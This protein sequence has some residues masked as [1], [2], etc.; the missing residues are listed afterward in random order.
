[1]TAVAL[2]APAAVAA[3]IR[4]A[5][6]DRHLLLLLDFDGT[7]CGFHPDPAAVVVPDRTQRALDQLAARSDVTVGVISGRRLH[8]VRSRLGA[9]ADIYV[10]GFHGLEIAGRDEAYFHPEAAAAAT[11]VRAI[12][13]TMRPALRGLPGVFIEDK[14]L[15]IALH[16]RDAT[17][18]VGVV[19]QRA[20]LDAAREDLDAGRLRVLPG[21]CVVELLPAASWHKGRALEWIRE[22]AEARHGPVFTVYVGD[23]VT[24]EDAFRAIGDAGLAVAASDRVRHARVRIDGPDGVERLL[25]CLD[26]PADHR[27]A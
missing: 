22:R 6:G 13:E 12:I 11:T 4:A 14:D 17:P 5:R 27:R 10:A 26:A 1:M 8:D 19:A 15:S 3:S 18:A 21:D 9:R 24:D 23:D 25:D 7:L 20:F 2:A 16:Y